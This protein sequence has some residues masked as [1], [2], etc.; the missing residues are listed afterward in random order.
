MRKPKHKEKVVTGVGWYRPE[1][2]QRLREISVDADQLENTQA[3]WLP[4]AEKAVKDLER[5]GISVIKVDV[6][7]EELLSWSRQQGLPLDG[8]ARA[9]FIE[10]KVRQMVKTR[11]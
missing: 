3:E 7:V 10:G 5:L 11:G 6:D 8:K 1:Q 4:V 2:W 9:Q